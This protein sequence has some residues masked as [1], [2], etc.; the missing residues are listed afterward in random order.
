MFQALSNALS[1]LYAQKAAM[2]VISHNIANANT[3]GYSR[4]RV[5]MSSVAGST[6]PA[7]YATGGV[8]GRGVQVDGVS[9]LRDVFLELRARLEH[10]ASGNLDRMQS[11]YK[12]LETTFGEPSDNGLQSQMADFWSSWDD[13]AARPT[14][15]SIRQQLIEKT[16]TLTTTFHRI[17]QGITDMKSGLQQE[18]TAKVSDLNNY[19]A[20]IASLNDAIKASVA[21]GKQPNDLL[22][23]RDLL[24][25]KMSELAPI[26]TFKQQLGG[27]DI[28]INGTPMVVGNKASTVEVDSSTATMKLRL[29]TDGDPNTTT[30]GPLVM[31]DNGDLGGLLQSINFTLPGVQTQLDGIAN[32]L[33]SAVNTQHALGKDLS[34]TAGGQFFDATATT[35]STIKILGAVSADP[36]LIAAQTASAAGANDGENARQM[37]ELF[38]MPNGPDS[39]Y[40]GMIS[41]LG[42][43]SNAAQQRSSLQQAIKDQVDQ[44]RQ[45]TS[46]VSLDE[47]M[48]ELI[49][50][51]HAYDAAAKMVT[52]VDQAIQSLLAAVQ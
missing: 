48:T 23:K 16:N 42:V 27:Q 26:T 14:D 45:N 35:A 52:T 46:G 25:L 2:D 33:V 5:D 17:S 36:T 1:G 43:Q 9:R 29:D 49:Q 8:T 39:T 21:A 28:Y 15:T 13:L 32:Q 18:V 11:T 3:E 10:S 20:Q 51:Q 24:T 40:R 37:A 31:V 41:T 30:E 4:Q 47:E 34:G 19:A 12:D 38:S 50:Y 6:T 22:D 7:F 44:E